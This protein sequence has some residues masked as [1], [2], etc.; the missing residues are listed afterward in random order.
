M[1]TL[2]I[3]PQEHK[4]QNIRRADGKFRPI[5][6]F[7]KARGRPP[8]RAALRPIGAKTKSIVSSPRAASK[9]S[10]PDLPVSPAVLLS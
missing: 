6:R 9:D 5:E 2:K 7:G 10:N 1:K 8:Q 3:T 4:Q